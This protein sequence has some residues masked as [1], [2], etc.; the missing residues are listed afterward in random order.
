MV[1][2]PLLIDAESIIILDPLNLLA[3]GWIPSNQGFFSC[4][5]ASADQLSSYYAGFFRVDEITFEE[6]V[7]S[8]AAIQVFLELVNI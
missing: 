5:R 1:E 2:L 4:I 8:Q 3:N 7:V 6:E